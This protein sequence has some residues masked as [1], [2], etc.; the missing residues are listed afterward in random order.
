M[1]A[2]GHLAQ[3]QYHLQIL[4]LGG[5]EFVTPTGRSFRHDKCRKSVLSG[6]QRDLRLLPH[7]LLSLRRWSLC[8]RSSKSELYS[9]CRY[10]PSRFCGTTNGASRTLKQFRF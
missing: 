9:T 1:L 3:A 8:R 5:E 2:G 4:K 10:L 7:I 6:P